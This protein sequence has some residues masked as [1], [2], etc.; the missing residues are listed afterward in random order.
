MSWTLH[1]NP[2]RVDEQSSSSASTRMPNSNSS[3]QPVDQAAIEAV[4]RGLESL[5]RRLLDLTNRNR[6]IS[7]RHGRTS[8][9]IVNVDLE[10]LYKSLLDE[11]TIPF[12]P[13]PEPPDEQFE[14][15]AE[16]PSAKDY[17][18]E[19]GWNTDFER[20]LGEGQSDCL[21]V[22]HYQDDFEIIIRK[23]GTSA[24]TALEE[25]GTNILHLIFGFLEWRESDDSSLIRQS[26]LLAIPVT[27]I[28][29]KSKDTDRSIRLQYTGEDLTAN[30]SLIEKMRRD[31]GLVIPDIEEGE[32]PEEYFQRF[33]SI[34]A[35]KRHWR[36][37]RHVSLALLSFGK[38]LMYLDLDPERWPSQAPLE[39]HPRLLDL[40]SGTA[41]Q[42]LSLAPEYDIDE[43]AD[44][45]DVPPLVNDA[46]S[47]QH[48]A[49]I[50]AIRGKNLVI[51]GPPGTG[52]SQTITNLIAASIAAG[53]RVLFVAE[54]MAALGVVKRRL[55]AC[56]LGE[57]CLELHSH[58]TSKVSLL[59]SLESRIQA[60]SRFSSPTTLEHKQSLLN[61]KRDQLR[62]YATLLHTPYAAIGRTPFELIWQRDALLSD[63]PPVL[64]ETNT[65]AFP[66]AF[67]WDYKAVSERKDAVT[68]YSAHL[69]RIQ[70][71]GGSVEK[72]ENPWGWLPTCELGLA[73]QDRILASLPL[74]VDYCSQRIGLLQVI[75]RTV[76]EALGNIDIWADK[77][78]AWIVGGIPVVPHDH[79]DLIEPLRTPTNRRNVEDF[80][81]S[82]S[83]YHE[84]IDTLPNDAQLLDRDLPAEFTRLDNE[85]ARMGLMSYSLATLRELDTA[86]LRVE[87]QIARAKNAARL[88]SSALGADTGFTLSSVTDLVTAR[89]LMSEAPLYLAHLRGPQFAKDGLVHLLEQGKQVCSALA[90]ER[91]SLSEQ[92]LVESDTPD[93]MLLDAASV[94]DQTPWY[95]RF[96]R[97][98]RA[99]SLVYRS[100][101]KLVQKRNPRQKAAGLRLLAHHRVKL[102]AFICKEQYREH[103]GETFQGMETNWEDL[104]V[105]ARW[106]EEL[107]TRL[108]EHQ[109][110]A[111]VVRN[112]LLTLPGARLRSMLSLSQ[113]IVPQPEELESSLQALTE[114]HALVPD[115]AFDCIDA[116]I[117][118]FLVKVRSIV[119]VSRRLLASLEP[120]QLK[121]S[122]KQVEI[123]DLLGRVETA[124]GL[125]DALTS[126]AG[127]SNVL[128]THYRGTETSPAPIAEVIALVDTVENSLLHASIKEWLLV[129]DYESRI[130]FLMKWM[131]DLRA[132]ETSIQEEERNVVTALKTEKLF[133]ER[134]SLEALGRA[135]SRL[136]R[137]V[138]EQALLPM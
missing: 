82:L 53:K 41:P 4:R 84:L 118:D 29:P 120:L 79:H 86:L 35:L 13:V 44:K 1:T 126:N 97:S 129:D 63:I 96:G 78:E 9:R 28:T 101:S 121:D 45:G 8:L 19:I 73:E 134:N 17:A 52:K 6:L 80:L 37:C 69:Q 103:L 125:R 10:T 114:L 130:S 70:G 110:F 76:S 133:G 128:S 64:R 39:R 38:L 74:L 94:L 137:C 108:P 77:T 122:C 2:S 7:F 5:R 24:R 43:E 59:R 105:V 55:D 131:K 14:L 83:A 98:F 81:T 119:A 135:V 57:F 124:R 42:G 25:S 102:T 71:S 113:G 93:Q 27:I 56:G 40:F 109:P 49:L 107:F 116:E 91:D 3:T 117:D 61:H 12:M 106:H 23:I 47:S 89:H 21:P 58:K 33:S 95:R 65:L 46:D 88:L 30:L 26:P 11:R 115:I 87:R 92:F 68:T 32:S 20:T 62:K 111:S 50:D 90:A 104:I 123:A 127:I 16:K 112:A 99:A 48:S 36:I 85:L 15:L 138:K 75:I 60:N 72:K 22:I 31:F 136:G 51:E 54:K 34:I 100:H 132:N 18:E 66:E 67:S